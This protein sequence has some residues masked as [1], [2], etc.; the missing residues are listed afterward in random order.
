[1]GVRCSRRLGMVLMSRAKL[2]TSRIHM[3]TM[4]TAAEAARTARDRVLHRSL[5]RL[6]ERVVEL[7]LRVGVLVVGFVC[8]GRVAPERQRR[9]VPYLRRSRRV[10]GSRTGG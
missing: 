2:A 5:W 8:G 9:R 10:E 3:T 4:S 6:I 7:C 1:M